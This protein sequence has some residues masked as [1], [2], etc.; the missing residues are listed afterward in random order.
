LLEK[1][2]IKQAIRLLAS[3]AAAAAAAWTQ[4]LQH[5][6]SRSYYQN[7]QP[8]SLKVLNVPIVYDFIRLM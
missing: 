2:N 3:A 8:N 5:I 7:R 4:L 6:C 1:E